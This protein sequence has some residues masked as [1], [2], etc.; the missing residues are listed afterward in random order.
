MKT[1][2]Q[3]IVCLLLAVS[4]SASGL[5][6]KSSTDETHHGFITAEGPGLAPVKLLRISAMVD[7]SGRIIFARSGVRYEHKSWTPPTEVIFDGEPWTDLHG[8][9]PAWRNGS[10][11]LDL[12]KAWIVNRKGRDVIA[13]EHTADGFDLYLCDAPN[14]SAPYEVIIAIPRRD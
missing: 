5:T 9:P 4:F 12:S 6:M 13:L 10:R 7:G 8:A 11:Q 1:Y 3:M 14:G 2:L